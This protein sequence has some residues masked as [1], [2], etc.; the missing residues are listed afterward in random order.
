M[1]GSGERLFGGDLFLDPVTGVSDKDILQTRAAVLNRLNMA[2]CI[3][4]TLQDGRQDRVGRS[5]T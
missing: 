5:N 1:S 3:S 4:D 2:A